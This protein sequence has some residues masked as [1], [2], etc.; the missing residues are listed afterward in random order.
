VKSHILQQ[1]ARI[2]ISAANFQ[3]KEKKGQ[4]MDISQSQSM[5]DCSSSGC[6]AQ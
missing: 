2:E 4:S 1:F 6:S 3:E 5:Q